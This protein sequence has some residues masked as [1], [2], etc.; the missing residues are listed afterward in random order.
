M[1]IRLGFVSNSSSSSY[2]IL[3]F[4]DEDVISQ[5]REKVE[6]G[7]LEGGG[8]GSSHEDGFL[9]FDENNLVGWDIWEGVLETKTLFRLKQEMVNKLA[10]VGIVVPIERIHLHQF[11]VWS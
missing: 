6:K 8:Q 4:T 3:G 7:A 9:F 2:L 1:K 10:S 11:E 5:V